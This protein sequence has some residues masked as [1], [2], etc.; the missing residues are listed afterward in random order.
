MI[1]E[2]SM[3]KIAFFVLILGIVGGVASAQEYQEGIP[4]GNAYFKPSV[5]LVF[6]HSDNVFLTDESMGEILDDNIW[7]IRPQIGLEFPFENS[8]V[9]INLQYEY[10]DYEDYD[11]LYHGTWF[12]VLDSQF[13]FSNGSTLN[14]SDHY[15][16]G[17][18][19]VSQ[20]D[21]DMESTW[22]VTRFQRNLAQV[23]YE[24]PVSTL[25][26]LGI[27]V[28][29]NEVNFKEDDDSGMMPFYSYVQKSGGLTWKYR[30][31]PLAAMVFEWEHTKSTPTDDNYLYSPIG[32]TTTE[33]EYNEDRLSVG[34]EGS[35]QR[36]LSGFAKI[37]YKRM[38][39][40]DH[41]LENYDDFKGIVADA[42]LTYKLAEFSD[43]NAVLFRHA[44]QSAFNVN[45]YYTST[46]ADLRFHHQFNRHLFATVG[47]KYQINDYPEAVVPEIPGYFTGIAMFNY[48]AGQHRNDDIAMFLAELGYHF[49]S[50][51]SMRFNYQ[52]EDRDSNLNYID[53]LHIER[54]PYSY[55]E[56]RFLLQIQMGW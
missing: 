10:K 42:G 41:T 53:M 2:R 17:A 54:K 3:K 7:Y 48:L 31:Q 6:T 27:H 40:E 43:L 56:N 8:Y 49:S 16:Y 30:Y 51:V 11:L 9:N 37:G 38:E 22:N 21:P 13:K 47:G 33:K 32:W 28:S 46:G 14:V 29:H 19:Q 34:W 55:N 5:E 4:W 35:A 44:S 24:I 45:N 23:R 1:K 15:V 50:R 52:Y 20:F 39:F 25:N 18:Q 36:K 26:S 12:G